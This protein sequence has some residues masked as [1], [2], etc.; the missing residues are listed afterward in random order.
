MNHDWSDQLWLMLISILMTHHTY[1]N[2][3]KTNFCLKRI[4]AIETIE[5]FRNFSCWIRFTIWT[6]FRNSRT[7]PVLHRTVRTAVTL[8]IQWYGKSNL[9]RAIDFIGQSMK[10]ILQE[11]TLKSSSLAVPGPSRLC[12]GY[13]WFD[14]KIFIDCR[15]TC[16]SW[17]EIVITKT[18]IFR[19]ILESKISHRRFG[20]K[21][22][23]KISKDFGLKII[24][25]I[26][27]YPVDDDTI[28]WSF[29]VCRKS[30][31]SRQRLLTLWVVKYMQ[32][33]ADIIEMIQWRLSLQPNRNENRLK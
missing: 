14:P 18:M 25:A 12:L 9:T 27:L 20:D 22:V 29:S 8:P 19:S 26:N 28:T 24:T 17:I 4:L 15:I 33:N 5:E 21:N 10:I 2:A 16:A 31:L 1:S 3:T 30:R 11:K 13:M 32:S 7:Q 6:W 23:L